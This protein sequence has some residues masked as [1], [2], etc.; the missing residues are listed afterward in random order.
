MNNASPAQAYAPDFFI[1]GAMKSGTSTLHAMLDCHPGAFLPRGEAFY[2]DLDDFAQHPDFYPYDGGRWQPMDFA[3]QQARYAAWYRALFAQAQP[4][5]LCG[6]DSTTYL[7]SRRAAPRIA[8][9]RPDAKILV[10]LRE[11]VARTYSQYWHLLRHGQAHHDFETMLRLYPQQ[12]LQ[13]SQ[14]LAQLEYWAQHFPREQIRVLLLEQ[15]RADPQRELA[16]VLEFLGLPGP[17]PAAAPQVHANRGVVPRWPTLQRW[18]NRLLWRRDMRMF[19]ARLPWIARP[20]RHW[21][22]GPVGAVLDTWHRRYNRPRRRPPP[23]RDSTRA[24]LREALHQDNAALDAH[25]QLDTA[26]WWAPPDSPSPN[27]SP[28]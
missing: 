3:G 14:Y 13:R 22:E 7:P 24:L 28:R 2:F 1:I 17:V 10:M 21:S 25:W 27:P 18:R 19:M 4:G 16:G 5:Q 6:E 20:P 15:L 26:R 23:L 12:L 9:L 11:P 8:A